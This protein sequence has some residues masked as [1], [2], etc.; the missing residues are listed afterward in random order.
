MSAEYIHEEYEPI[1]DLSI[2]GM[3]GVEEITQKI[4]NYLLDWRKD[5][6]KEKGISSYK[7]NAKYL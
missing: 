1:A 7:L 3:N 4:D 2:I 6:I 5:E